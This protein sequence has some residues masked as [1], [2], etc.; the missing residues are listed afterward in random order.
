MSSGPSRKRRHHHRS[1]AGC[2]T[3]KQRH[4]RCDESKP[5]WCVLSPWIDRPQLTQNSHNCLKSGGSC[6]Y[7]TAGASAANS[8]SLELSKEADFSLRSEPPFDPSFLGTADPF[9]ALA[10]IAS[11][12]ST[13]LFD[14]G[15]L[16]VYVKS[17]PEPFYSSSR[18]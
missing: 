10:S 15:K 3:C 9:Q 11:E 2:I 14:Q 18:C 7:T 13:L 16:P 8:P 12:Y 17:L 1:R 4:M 6:G 5:Y